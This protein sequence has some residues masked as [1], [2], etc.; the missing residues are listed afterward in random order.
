MFY[1]FFCLNIIFNNLNSLQILSWIST[2]A[3]SN[4][5]LISKQEIGNTFEGRPMVLLKVFEAHTQAGYQPFSGKSN[6]SY[7]LTTTAWQI[8][9]HY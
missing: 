9:W 1:L 4:P 7:L 6:K 3:S 5:S 2:I 8:L